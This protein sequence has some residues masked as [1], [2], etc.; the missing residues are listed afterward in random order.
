MERLLDQ[1]VLE[2]V[3]L[4]AVDQQGV[5]VND[6]HRQAALE[7]AVIPWDDPLSFAKQQLH[8]LQTR[9]EFPG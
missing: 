5:F 8:R 7:A 9:G 3:P 2:A 4:S 6:A 1:S